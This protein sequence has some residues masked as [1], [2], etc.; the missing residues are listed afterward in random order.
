MNGFTWEYEGRSSFGPP[1]W[2]LRGPSGANHG[3]IDAVPGGWIIYSGGDPE[4]YAAEEV[5]ETAEEAKAVCYML[6]R[7][8][9]E[10][11]HHG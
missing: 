7:M 3:W 8:K 11:D 9:G 10:L 5:Y 2:C 6:L 1:A 4:N